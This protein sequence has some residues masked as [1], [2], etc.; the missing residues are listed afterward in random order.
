[1]AGLL[2]SL[3]PL[4]ELLLKRSD[5][6]ETV[7][8]L[9]SCADRGD[10]DGMHQ[11]LGASPLASTA[12]RYARAVELTGSIGPAARD[13]LLRAE[14]LVAERIGPRDVWHEV[15]TVP[16]YLRRALPEGQV[17]ETLPTLVELVATAKRRIVLASPFLDSGFAH[18]APLLRRFVHA[19]G[20]LLV[21]T[22]ELAKPHS[23]NATVIRDLR[24]SCVSGTLQVASWEEEGLGLHLKALV[25]D[26]HRAYVG[27]ANFTWGGIGQ[28]AE[29][30]L[31]IEG[32]SVR[33]I[34]Q[35]LEV[36]AGELRSRRHF[37]AR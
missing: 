9:L 34:E 18:I 24:T 5:P 11:A 23:H 13:Q 19:G 1:M 16:P 30:G 36:L 28:H 14:V 29:L 21:I 10:V 33:N 7:R 8:S 22:R 20:S 2:E 32:P 27:S 25:A 12:L 6:L 3:E 15:L 31:R 17:S 4:L 35:L 37:E 26:S